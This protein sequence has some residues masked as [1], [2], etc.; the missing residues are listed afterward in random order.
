LLVLASCSGSGDGPAALEPEGSDRAVQETTA[1]AL[2]APPDPSGGS[3]AREVGEAEG[4]AETAEIPLAESSF[5]RRLRDLREATGA[6]RALALEERTPA[7]RERYHNDLLQLGRL[8]AN[9]R[10]DGDDGYFRSMAAETFEE[11]AWD[12]GE[13]SPYG[14]LAYQ[15]LADLAREGGA[16]EDAD[17]FDEAIERLL[18]EE[19]G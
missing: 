14:V 18:D 3:G 17:A 7:L 1:G 8:L 12:A 9:Y 6:Y 2:A 11:L 4:E 16:T 13:D 5:Q 10:P 15:A 19:D